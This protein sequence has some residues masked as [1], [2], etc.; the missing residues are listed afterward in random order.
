MNEFDEGTPVLVKYPAPGMTADTPR[1]DW[2]WMPGTIEE[3]CGAGEWLVAVLDRQVGTEEDGTPAMDGTPD[4][5]LY[6]PAVFPRRH[7]DPGGGAMSGIRWERTPDRR[8]WRASAG[9]LL[10]TASRLSSGAWAGAVEGP[11]VSE[12]SPQSSAPAWPRKA[13]QRTARGVRGDGGHRPCLASAGVRRGDTGCRRS[14]WVDFISAY[15]ETVAGSTPE[16]AR[17]PADAGR[18]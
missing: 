18:H 12:R 3:V 6:C 2:P 7:R 15:R 11:G 17:S 5:D 9:A 8:T 14:G 4:D 13:G 1:E 10:L 16:R